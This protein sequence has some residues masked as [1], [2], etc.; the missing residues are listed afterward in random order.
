M[1]VL[2]RFW[3]FWCFSPLGVAPLLGWTSG[4]FVGV[5]QWLLCWGEPMA[6]RAR[7]LRGALGR[8]P[9]PVCRVEILKKF[10]GK[11]VPENYTLFFGK[12]TFFLSKR[13]ETYL[14]RQISS[15]QS[16][17]I[18][19]SKIDWRTLELWHFFSTLHFIWFLPIF[20]FF[21][22]ALPNR[23]WQAL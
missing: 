22:Y 14:E 6:S 9:P 7:P 12:N 20:Q 10:T 13:S 2:W 17:R 5:N 16:G 3:C 19:L 18:F 4:S 1:T 21:A 11:S 8:A 15:R 23:I